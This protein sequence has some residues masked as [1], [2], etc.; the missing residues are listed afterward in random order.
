MSTKINVVF[1]GTSSCAPVKSRNLTS[2]L[3]NYQGVN[4]L[5]DASENTQQ[6][7]MKAEQSIM[8]IDCIFITHMH[9]DH[10]FGILGLLATMQLNNREKELQL[11]VPAGAKRQLL[12][13]IK[14]SRLKLGYSLKINEAKEGIA[15]SSGNVIVSAVKLNH[16]INTLGYVFKIKDK[17]GKFNKQK[18]V[19]LGIPEGPLYRQLQEG[20]SIKVD[21]K[22]IYPKDVI[23]LKFKK[24]GTSI[25]Y[26]LD[27]M[28]LKKIPKAIENAD[29]LVHEAC[30]F[31]D[32]R[33]KAKE[34]KHS[35]ASEVAV[36]AKKAK[37]KSL[38]LVHISPRYSDLRDIG[39][40]VSKTFKNTKYPN[41]L[42]KV[43]IGDYE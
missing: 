41:D 30:F 20:K 11:F 16:S 22:I 10:Y 42:D 39:K 24:K 31:E 2:M 8:K 18:A 19:K 28:V 14:S 6:Q 34:V 15:Y 43:E 3:I 25:A 32:M 33:E 13:F 5:F 27:T 38:Y 7:I 36:F 23:D 4:Y 35:V 17:V 12:D 26:L 40:E 29:I 21:G 37:V 9:G 1:L